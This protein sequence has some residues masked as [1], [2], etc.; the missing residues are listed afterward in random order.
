MRAVVFLFFCLTS[1]ARAAI[2]L[3]QQDSIDLLKKISMAAHQV[4]YQGT[5]IFQRDGRIESTRIYH[6][7]DQ[8]GEH[9]KLVRLDGP[10]REIICNDGQM[11]FYY[12]DEK[13]MMAERHAVARK[14]FPARITDQ[15]QTLSENYQVEDDGHERLAG[16]ESRV[17]LLTPKDAFRYG[18]KLWIEQATDLLLKAA[19]I[20]N[21]NDVIEQFAF[22]YVKIGGNFDKNLLKPT[23]PVMSPRMR[24]SQRQDNFRSG[25][26]VENL[27]P[28]FRK[29]AEMKRLFRGKSY[30]VTHLVYSDGI[31]AVSVFI[32]PLSAGTRPMQGVAKQGAVNLYAHPEDQYQITVV[33]ETPEITVRQIGDSVVFKGKERD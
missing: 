11:A 15:L 4:T 3:Q 13:A 7:A 17:L 6:F 20:G 14:G 23:L 12:P 22:T 26:E 32:E 2:P 31:V 33:G 8:S 28:G 9:E 25:W 24:D 21:D 27:P 19:M 5:F 30:P 16:Y 1:A 29:I 10:A 18:H